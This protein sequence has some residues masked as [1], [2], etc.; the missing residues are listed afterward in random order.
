MITL[1]KKELSVFFSSLIGPIIIC[2]FLIIN[3]FFLWSN[4]SDFNILDGKYATMDIF[5]YISPLIFLLFVPAMSMRSFSEEYNSGTIELLMTNPISVFDIV[6]SKFLA[7]F[8]LVVISIV[9]TFIYTFSIYFLGETIGNLDLAGII[10]SYISLLMLSSSLVSIGIFSS[11]I[12][13]N[14]IIA[15]TISII[16][17][18]FIFFGFDFLSNINALQPFNII[19][20]KMGIQY[21]YTNMSKGLLQLSD[22]IYFISLSI[23]YLMFSEI[24]V[25]NRKK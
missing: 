8:T 18:T 24:I 12:S 25:L 11:T 21:H 7:I 13:S 23:F 14:Q 5:F 10:G 15:F 4:F 16:I 17:S 9:P 3:W 20:R 19:L 22:L 1:Y 2:L 6:F